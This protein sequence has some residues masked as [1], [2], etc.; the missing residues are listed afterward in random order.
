MQFLL[1]YRK[2]LENLSFE[3]LL[4]DTIFYKSIVEDSM[5]KLGSLH[6]YSPTVLE[7]RRSRAHGRNDLGVVDVLKK[8]NSLRPRPRAP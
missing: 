8:K 5:C 1:E 6:S 4:K 2:D 3:M 7:L